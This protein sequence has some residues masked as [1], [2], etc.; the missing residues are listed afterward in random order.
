MSEAAISPTGMA[1]ARVL[2]VSLIGHSWQRRRVRTNTGPGSTPLHAAPAIRG[3]TQ[4]K[5]LLT[6]VLTAAFVSGAGLGTTSTQCRMAQGVVKRCCC[7]GQNAA[8]ANPCVSGAQ[9]QTAFARL[10]CCSS[11]QLSALS[12][13]AT[14]SATGASGRDLIDSTPVTAPQL[15]ALM[16]L[17]TA[18]LVDVSP[19]V[20]REPP[21]A[22]GPPIP[23]RFRHLLI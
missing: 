20:E 21:S 2:N 7:H 13:P 10:P 12:V 15:I 9:E 5:A 16:M 8:R 1:T 4:I 22:T 11:E 18:D 23:I 6:A 14:T 19:V 17:P 3:A